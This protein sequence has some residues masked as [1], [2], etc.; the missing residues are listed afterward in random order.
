MADEK[1]EPLDALRN[2]IILGEHY[3]YATVSSGVSKTVIGI[4]EK[5]SKSGL[6]TLSVLKVNHFIYGEAYDS[7]FH[8]SEKVNIRP[9]MLF[10]INKDQ[11]KG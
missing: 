10:K 6:V 3:G 1:F 5:F 7:P 9:H 2:E 4:A 8:N 11:L